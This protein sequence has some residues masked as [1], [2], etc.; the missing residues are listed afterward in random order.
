MNW[1]VRSRPRCPWW[2]LLPAVLV[3]VGLGAPAAQASCG[4]YVV[5]GNKPVH[6]GDPAGLMPP[7]LPAAPSPPCHGP[8]CSGN[9]LPQ[10]PL[11]PAPAPTTPVGQEWA[12]LDGCPDDSR[13]AL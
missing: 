4:S 5:I 13:L 9:P 12:L 2:T 3:G 6:T 1:P 7:V 11:A 8:F 10:T